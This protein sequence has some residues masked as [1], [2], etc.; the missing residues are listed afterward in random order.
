VT[1]YANPKPYPKPQKNSYRDE[2]VSA[3]GSHVAGVVLARDLPHLSHLA[4]RARQEQTPLAT[5]EDKGAHLAASAMAGTTVS[6]FKSLY[7]R[8]D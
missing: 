8:L 5:S 3:A 7:G 1:V 4:I 2:E 6:F